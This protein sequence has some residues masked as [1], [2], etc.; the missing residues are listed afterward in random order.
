M[1]QRLNYQKEL[2]DLHERMIR[3]GSDV[4]EAIHT[5]V[6]SLIDIDV[7]LAKRVITN[8]DAIDDQEREINQECVMLIARQQ[9]VASDLREITSDMKLTT[10]LERMADH[11]EDIADHVIAIS[12]LA[13]KVIVPHDIVQ[14]ASQTQNMI[15]AAIDAYVSADADKA[16]QVILMDSN[17]DNLYAN[18]KEYLV[19][20]MKLDPESADIY[21]EMLLICKHLER[22]GDHS[23]NVA[24]WIIYHIEGE[25]ASSSE[26]RREVKDE[27]KG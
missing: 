13:H 9:P 7:N 27:D 5:A 22:I 14:L 16:K 6:Q 1:T 3:M 4:E 12:K 24:E 26:I 15:H 19:K 11:A 17:I 21:V 23:E 8:D 2:R 20:Q 10:D 18:M 25:Y